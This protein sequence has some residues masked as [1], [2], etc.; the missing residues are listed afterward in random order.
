MR[1]R[2]HDS[3]GNVEAEGFISGCLIGQQT[4]DPIQEDTLYSADYESLEDIHYGVLEDANS[5]T[6]RRKT[7]VKKT[8]LRR[9]TFV[10]S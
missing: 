5:T 10:S 8:F 2:D 9:K 3:G 4:V 6:L 1:Q 7:W